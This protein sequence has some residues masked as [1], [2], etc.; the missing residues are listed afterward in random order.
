MREC[1]AELFGVGHFPG[2]AERNGFGD[3]GLGRRDAGAA[4]FSIRPR[5]LGGFLRRLAGGGKRL[6]RLFEPRQGQPRFGRF[7]ARSPD[8]TITVAMVPVRSHMPD[9]Y[10]AGGR[11]VRVSAW[12]HRKLAVYTLS[13][14]DSLQRRK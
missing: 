13:C 7:A 2:T 5:G 9:G 8:A 3:R 1:L 14:V 4:A 10:V 11:K 12:L 6:L